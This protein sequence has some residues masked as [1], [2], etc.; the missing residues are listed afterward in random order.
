MRVADKGSCPHRAQV[1]L[2][3]VPTV[4]IVDSGADI[5]IIGRELAARNIQRG[6]KEQYD[7]G[8][9]TTNL[10]V[11]EWVFVRFPQDESG[12]LRKLS[13]PWHGP[14]R[15]V[16]KEDPDITAYHPQH[17]EIRV[18]Q[19]RVCKC[20]VNFPAGYYWYGGRNKGPGRPPKWVDK[21]LNSPQPTQQASDGSGSEVIEPLAGE[22]CLREETGVPC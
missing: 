20:P 19:S 7:R 21:F 15:I 14:Y 5:T 13:R 2:Q 16:Q 12:R 4:G 11:G 8:T 6:Y 18:H 3:G 22:T 17:G 10:R 1:L 9:R